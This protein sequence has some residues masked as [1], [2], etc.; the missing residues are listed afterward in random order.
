MEE[1]YPSELLKEKYIPLTRIEEHGIPV[2][3]VEKLIEEKRIHYAEFKEDGKYI[4]SPHVNIEEVQSL[5]EK[6]AFLDE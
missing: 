1:K 3:Y 4:R 2:S 6:G 5:Y